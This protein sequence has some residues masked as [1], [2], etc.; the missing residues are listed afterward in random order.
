MPRGKSHIAQAV[1]S[2][3][4]MAWHYLTPAQKRTLEAARRGGD[5]GGDPNKAPYWYVQDV[6][7]ERVG[8]PAK[9]YID[10]AIAAIRS[11]WKDIAREKIGEIL[12]I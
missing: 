4:P 2:P 8:I 12:G 11:R 10:R 7:M 9:G 6:G 3:W 1:S 5:Y